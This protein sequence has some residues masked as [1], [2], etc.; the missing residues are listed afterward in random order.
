MKAKD[1]TKDRLMPDGGTQVCN[2]NFIQ[3][4]WCKFIELLDLIKDIVD[5]LING[6]YLS[7]NDDVSNIGG[8]IDNLIEGGDG[9]VSL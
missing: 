2:R 6:G 1:L 3:R 7:E 8:I 4:L 9:V 5:K